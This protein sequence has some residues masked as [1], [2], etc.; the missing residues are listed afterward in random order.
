MMPELSKKNKTSDWSYVT[1]L[2]SCYH[3][4]NFEPMRAIAFLYNQLSRN[5]YHWKFR[6]SGFKHKNTEDSIADLFSLKSYPSIPPYP[7]TI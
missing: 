3:W 7:L 5:D 6:T 4:D 2:F 1:F